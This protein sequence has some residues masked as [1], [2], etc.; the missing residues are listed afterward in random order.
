MTYKQIKWLI[1]LIPTITI[2]L[3]EYIRHEFLLPYISMELGN[4]LA[5]VIVFLV[6]MIF[7]LKL[8]TIFEQMKED[9]EKEKSQKSILEEREKLSRELHD[10]I[11]Q[12][13]FLVSV[14]FNQLEQ[15]EK[16]LNENDT[17]QKLKKT[18]QHIHEDVRQAIFNLR[19][20]KNEEAFHWTNSL[21]SLIKNFKE[22]T[23]IPVD[24]DWKLH[25]NKL[26]TKEKTELYACIKEALMNIRKHAKSKHVWIRSEDTLNGWTCF[27][28]DDGIGFD[29]NMSDTGYGLQIMKDR[30]K[31]MK[32]NFVIERKEEKTQVMIRKVEK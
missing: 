13:L 25:E 7:V 5:P 10:G 11:A 4:L 27:I 19:N 20:A 16:Q 3:W 8:F 29:P 2:G 1:L 24:L 32:W 15:K 18:I 14:K 26:S 17:Y 31:A 12:S 22:D 21:T 23:R 9:L 30:A 28:E 6:T